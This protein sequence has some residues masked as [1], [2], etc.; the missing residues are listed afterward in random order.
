MSKDRRQKTEDRRQKTEVIDQR[1]NGKKQSSWHLTIQ[2]SFLHSATVEFA[3]VQDPGRVA[4]AVVYWERRRIVYNVVL[5]AGVVAWVVLSWPH[6][7]PVMTWFALGQL[8][9][10][11]AIANLLF[12][13]AYLAEGAIQIV[14]TATARRRLRAVVW[15]GGMVFALLL[16]SYWIADEIYP[17]V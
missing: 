3:R 10:L 17:F 7:R 4:R 1:G 6:F 11:G 13:A 16:E 9:I 2:S 8:L 5:A 12:C 15:I 14:G